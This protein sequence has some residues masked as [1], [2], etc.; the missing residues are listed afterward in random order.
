MVYLHQRGYV[1]KS[2]RESGQG[3]YDIAVIPQDSSKLGILME[4][5]H[6][7]GAMQVGTLEMDEILVASPSEALSQMNLKRYDTELRKAGISKVYQIA[8]AFCGKQFQL[9]LQY[10]IKHL[11]LKI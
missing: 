1:I 7:V 2:N 3:H 5:K 6:V 8:L 4:L 11:P 10:K 9:Q